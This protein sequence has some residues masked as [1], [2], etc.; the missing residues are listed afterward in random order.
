[1]RD[2]HTTAMHAPPRHAHPLCHACP[3]PCM[4]PAMQ[5]TPHACPS[6]TCPLC[7][8]CHP[9]VDRILDTRFWKYYLAPTSLRAVKNQV[10]KDSLYYLFIM[11]NLFSSLIWEVFH[12]YCKVIV[13]P[14]IKTKPR[15]QSI[16][17]LSESS[18]IL[19]SGTYQTY[20]RMHTFKYE[21]FG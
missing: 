4:P 13:R 21:K 15:I 1:M 9:P 5:P 20:T 10:A 16:W 14:K 11:G 12:P 18:T 2:T 6:H 19:L 3:P 8:T 17:R 7:H